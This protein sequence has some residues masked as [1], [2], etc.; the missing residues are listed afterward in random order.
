MRVHKSGKLQEF[1]NRHHIIPGKLHTYSAHFKIKFSG[2]TN[3]GGQK[4]IIFYDTYYAE[5]HFVFYVILFVFG[6]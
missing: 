5:I 1:Q 3:L 2:D 4:N 6:K